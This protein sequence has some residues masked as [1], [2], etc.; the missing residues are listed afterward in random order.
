[1]K[2]IELTTEQRARIKQLE[3]EGARKAQPL[4]AL[5]NRLQKEK[6]LQEAQAQAAPIAKRL[7]QDKNALQL[8]AAALYLGEG[9]KGANQLSFC[10][11]DAQVLRTWM[12]LL[13]RNFE[14]DESKFRCQLT[15]SIGMDEQSLKAYWSDVTGIPLDRFI[16]STV[17]K[18]TACGV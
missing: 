13:R 2:D 17:D 7:S 12:T 18:K 14:I 10:N 1:M 4:G 9:A 15:I 16:R 11:S 5:W 3:V 8:M 6:R